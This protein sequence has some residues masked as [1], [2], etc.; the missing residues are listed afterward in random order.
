MS[1]GAYNSYKLSLRHYTG[2]VPTYD[3]GYGSGRYYDQENNHLAALAN[4]GVLHPPFLLV[5]SKVPSQHSRQRLL[6][7]CLTSNEFSV[8][9]RPLHDRCQ[10]ILRKLSTCLK[11]RYQHAFLFDT[12]PERDPISSEC[13]RTLFKLIKAGGTLRHMQ[14]SSF[15]LDCGDFTEYIKE[16]YVDLTGQKPFSHASDNYRYTPLF[17]EYLQRHPGECGLSSDTPRTIGLKW[18]F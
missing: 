12:A 9:T 13:L 7:L 17:F 4:F 5:L 8:V 6:T 2:R 1:I 18:T 15:W 14:I 3:S 16:A 10:Q 11:P